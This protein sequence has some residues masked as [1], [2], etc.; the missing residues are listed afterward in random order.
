[1]K[2]FTDSEEKADKLRTNNWIVIML[3]FLRSDD[4]KLLLG[5]KMS[6]AENS[7]RNSAS[8]VS[9]ISC[10]CAEYTIRAGLILLISLTQ[11]I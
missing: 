11:A 9:R 2:Y 8:A 5:L 7:H 6:V 10:E 3:T 4:L 1:M